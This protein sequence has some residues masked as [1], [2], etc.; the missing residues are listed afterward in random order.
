MRP[1]W[2]SR[3]RTQG[4]AGIGGA[5]GGQQGQQRHREP[6]GG[7]CL[8]DAHSESLQRKEGRECTASGGCGSDLDGSGGG[9]L[10]ALGGSPRRGTGRGPKGGQRLA[11]H[12]PGVINQ[13]PLP[14]SP[15]APRNPLTHDG[16]DPCPRSGDS[17]RGARHGGA[18]SSSRG[19]RRGGSERHLALHAPV[20][21]HPGLC[22]ADAGGTRVEDDGPPTRMPPPGMS[23]ATCTGPSSET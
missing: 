5:T 1:S 8:V 16:G 19:A 15:R 11:P 9:R 10:L 2:Y 14:T 17:Q 22:P 4:L 18:Y 13:G 3:K 6:V 21:H 12:L 7:G 23:C 20:P